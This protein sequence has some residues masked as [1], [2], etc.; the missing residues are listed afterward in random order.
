[1]NPPSV[2]VLGVVAFSGTGKTT[3]LQGLIPLLVQRGLRVG[4]IK[5]THHDFEI[6]QPGK[7]SYALRQAGA[8]Q[9]LISS[10]QRWAVIGETPEQTRPPELEQMLQ[11]L[12]TRELDLVLVEGFKYARLPKLELRR[13]ALGKPLL[14][15]EDPDIIALVTDTGSTQQHPIPVLDLNNPE[16][17]LAFILARLPHDC[18]DKTDMA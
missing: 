10:T 4:V 7:D 8:R 6:D 17:I 14:Y 16:Q 11:H 18:G 3:L 9:T 12:D 1:M 13:E 5:H 15:P 2:A